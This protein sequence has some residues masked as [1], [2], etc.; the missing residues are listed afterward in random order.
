MTGPK[1]R[2]LCTTIHR[3]IL[4]GFRAAVVEIDVLG[5]EAAVRLLE[6]AAGR[7]AG[8]SEPDWAPGDVERILTATDRLPQ[9][10]ALVGAAIGKGGRTCAAVADDL[11]SGRFLGG[12]DYAGAFAAMRVALDAL[13]EDDARRYR[14]LAIFREDEPIPRIA[15]ETLWRRGPDDVQALVE[16]L[17]KWNLVTIQA[18]ASDAQNTPKPA[19]IRVKQALLLLLADDLMENHGR[20]LEAYAC[21]CSSKGDWATLPDDDLYIWDHLVHHMHGAR[22]PEAL[23][24]VARDVGF[25]AVHAHLSGPHAVERD[26]ATAAGFLPEDRAIAWLDRFLETSGHLLAGHPDLATL[27][28]S[29]R[30]M[31]LDAPEGID[32]GRLESLSL[33]PPLHLRPLWRRPRLLGALVREACLYE[34]AINAL[35]FSVDGRLA[36]GG[37]KGILRIWDSELLGQPTEIPTGVGAIRALAF[38]PDGRAIVTGGSDGSVRIWDIGARTCEALADHGDASVCSVAISPDGSQVASCADDGSVRTSRVGGGP[39]PAVPGDGAKPATAVAYSPRGDVLA[40]GGDQGRVRIWNL[41]GGAGDDGPRRRNRG[42][43]VDHVLAGRR[44]P[45]LR[46]AVRGRRD[47]GPRGRP[48]AGDPGGPRH[49]GDGRRV[50][51]HGGAPAARLGQRRWQRPALAAAR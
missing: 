36:S 33:L 27:A 43:H 7:R 12:G 51:A 50:L 44:P 46:G 2:T 28:A 34:T 37:S 13:P 19:D 29:L 11:A 32:P 48:G 21:R 14:Q 22:D 26:L 45:G 40:L 15:L 3:S 25:L 41:G 23:Q 24:A 10:L 8:G 17:A 31:L 18:T 20:L 6:K 42:G 30:L 38:A 16:T 4:G 35:A 1:G 9:A 47:V 49:L 5:P 39:A